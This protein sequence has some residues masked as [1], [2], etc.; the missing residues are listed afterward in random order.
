MLRERPSP[1]KLSQEAARKLPRWGLIALLLVFSACG[2]WMTGLWTLRDAAGFGAALSVMKGD[3][4][5]MLMPSVID[6]PVTASGPLTAWVSAFFIAV[7]GESGYGLKICSDVIALRLAAGFWFSLSC[8]AL[9][10][11]TWKL[12]RR[13]EAQP[14][15]F[16]FGGE[17]SPRDYGR[18]VA[19]STV[20]LFVA[21]FGLVMIQHEAL[22][23]TGLLAMGALNFF[24]LAAALRRPAKGFFVA[25]LAVGGAVLASTV[26]S[27]LWLLVISLIISFCVPAYFGGAAKRALSLLAGALLPPALWIGASFAVAPETA[28]A[29]FAAWKAEQLSLFGLIRLDT[30]LWLLRNSIWFLFPLWPLALRCLYSWRRQLNL[31]HIRMPLLLCAGGLLAGIFSSPD[32]IETVFIIFTP[33]LAVLAA[34]GLMSLRHGNENILDWF[35]ITVFTL[36]TLTLWTYWFA[37]LTNFAPK[38]AFSIARLAPGAS[39]H[40]DLGLAAAVA[41]TALWFAFVLWRLTHRPVVIW[42]GPWLAAAGLTAVIAVALSLFH[43]AADTNRSYAPVAKTLAS[44]LRSVGMNEGECIAGYN[45]PSGLQAI[46]YYYGGFRTYRGEAADRCRYG[47]VRSRDGKADPEGALPVPPARRPHTDEIFVVIRNPQQ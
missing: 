12:A 16:A 24:G 22:P 25:G 1:V 32:A 42:R 3:A 43:G 14:I 13:P 41:V 7:F 33:A 5:A 6:S 10:Y 40:A 11:G 8:A 21:T 30:L 15:Q 20:L 19:D 38:M 17:A 39:A 4:A 37:W 18:A 47:I 23:D 45:L 9:W 28:Q 2:F 31:T 44:T 46:F 34:F 36:G 35:A 27:G 29:W 26:F